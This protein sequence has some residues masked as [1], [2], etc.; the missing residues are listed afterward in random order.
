MKPKRLS[1]REILEIDDCAPSMTDIPGVLQ[2]FAG[3]GR[4]MNRLPDISPDGSLVV[5]MD[6]ADSFMAK[7]FAAFDVQKF[8]CAYA[9]LQPPPDKIE[10]LDRKAGRSL[11]KRSV[12]RLRIAKVGRF[13]SSGYRVAL[14]VTAGGSILKFVEYDAS[15]PPDIFAF[16][17]TAL[18]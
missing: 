11:A 5:L 6:V 14:H 2:V 8:P 12:M 7:C 13:L 15:S 10:R 3:Y 9:S 18:R 4:L 16:L 17:K 1:E